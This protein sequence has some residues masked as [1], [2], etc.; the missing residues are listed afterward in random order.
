MRVTT[1]CTLTLLASLAILGVDGSPNNPD[2]DKNCSTVYPDPCGT[3]CPAHNYTSAGKE[4]LFSD[5][6]GPLP[7]DTAAAVRDRLLACILPTV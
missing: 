7:N 2:R 5:F 1:P 6:F 3:G 4:M